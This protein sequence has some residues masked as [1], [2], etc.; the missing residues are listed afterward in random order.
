MENGLGNRDVVEG[1]EVH[2]QDRIDY[3][4]AHLE[5]VLE[6]RGRGADVRG[7]YVWTLLDNFEWAWGYDKRFGLIHVDFADQRRTV[8]DS[9]RWY[10]EV[11]ERNGL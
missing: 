5:A 3:L 4:R 9:A 1:G 8:K 7:Y 11:I 6:A 10:A 2:D